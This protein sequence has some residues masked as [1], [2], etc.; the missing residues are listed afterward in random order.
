MSS[1]SEALDGALVQ[2]L[3]GIERALRSR[4]AWVSGPSTL[5]AV[6]QL[7]ERE[8]PNCRVL[9][10]ILDPLAPHG[11]GEPVLSRLVDHLSV[12]LGVELADTGLDRVVAT[13]EDARQGVRADVVLYGPAWTI[14][15]EAKIWAGERELQG[16]DLE[17]RWPDAVYVFLTRRGVTMKSVGA[18]DWVPLTWERVGA[19]IGTALAEAEQDATPTP[20]SVTAR[21]AV[22]DYLIATGHLEHDS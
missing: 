1:T 8:V 3:V 14:V 13:L 18:T 7:V 9:G 17:A 6:L 4:G 2:R 12:E 21:A 15:I 20:A 10:W 16:A 22:R 11:L 19:W 5:F